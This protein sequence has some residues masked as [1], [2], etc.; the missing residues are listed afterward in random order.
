V[1]EGWFEEMYRTFLAHDEDEL[2]EIIDRRADKFVESL[3]SEYLQYLAWEILE[4]NIAWVRR[5]KREYDP[6]EGIP[7]GVALILY[8]GFTT[9]QRAWLMAVDKVLR[10]GL[11]RVSVVVESI[12]LVYADYIVL[13]E[14]EKEAVEAL[15][16]Y[17]VKEGDEL[18]DV[19]GVKK[20]DCEGKKVLG[21]ISAE[22]P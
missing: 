5:V 11:F 2:V 19:L 15:K 17:L 1:V 14:N 20:I 4:K 12:E 6:N 13:A 18:K 3:S 8:Q 9:N 10:Q 16:E 22:V 21:I 7:I